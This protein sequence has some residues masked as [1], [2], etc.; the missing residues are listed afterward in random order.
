M[1]GGEASGQGRRRRLCRACHLGNGGAGQRPSRSPAVRAAGRGP[2]GELRVDLGPL[3]R[4]RWCRA[5][6]APFG[7]LKLLLSLLQET[8]LRCFPEPRATPPVT[9]PSAW[10]GAPTERGRGALLGCRRAWAHLPATP[11]VA[12]LTS[13]GSPVSNARRTVSKR[14]AFGKGKHTVS[15]LTF[16]TERARPPLCDNGCALS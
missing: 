13:R 11:S 12:G 6:W 15:G 10:S 7:F 1:P 2:P 8:L 16:K 9:P 5:S 3:A 4:H 14:Q